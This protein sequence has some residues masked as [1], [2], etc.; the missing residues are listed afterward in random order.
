MLGAP[1]NGV[2]ETVRTLN[3]LGRFYSALRTGAMLNTYLTSLPQLPT[4][5]F[6]SRFDEIDRVVGTLDSVMCMLPRYDPFFRQSY[7]AGKNA[8]V[9][10]DVLTRAKAYLAII[11]DVTGELPKDTIN[12][13]VGDFR[14]T[15]YN[16]RDVSKGSSDLDYDVTTL[17]DGAVTIEGAVIRGEDVL[18]HHCD[19]IDEPNDYRY[20][21]AIEKWIDHDVALEGSGG[22]FGEI[23][24]P[25][26]DDTKLQLATQQYEPLNFLRPDE[27]PPDP[28]LY[29]MGQARTIEPAKIEQTDLDL[30][31]TDCPDRVVVGNPPSPKLDQTLATTNIG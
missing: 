30:F 2:F 28:L 26:V 8:Y 16:L 11:D 20:L 10:Q 18:V 5:F 27:V 6:K 1:S 29:M 7:W 19:H 22:D 14:Q 21:D 13:G 9:T 24:P 15:Y 23:E 25:P 12:N 3:G 4:T 17:G 31:P